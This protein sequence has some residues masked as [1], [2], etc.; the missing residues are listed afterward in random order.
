VTPFDVFDPV[1]FEQDVAQARRARRWRRLGAFVLL[2][3]ACYGVAFLLLKVFGLYPS[4]RPLIALG[5]APLMAAALLSLGWSILYVVTSSASAILHP[6]GRGRGPVSTSVA[7]ALFTRGEL[8][9]S[10]AAFDALRARHGETAALLR[11]EADLELSRT[12]RP[13]RARELLI[14]LRRASDV[15]GGD[16]LYATQRLIDLYLGSLGDEARAGVELRRLV[17]RFPGTADAAG[18]QVAL[19]RIR[20]AR[21]TP[22]A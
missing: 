3:A 19:E 18:A 15:S 10:A 4:T 6:G 8:D 22:P 14:R 20:A 5:V 11:T 16:E 7:V 9:E 13:A 17:D 2:S 21:R 1:V 12:G